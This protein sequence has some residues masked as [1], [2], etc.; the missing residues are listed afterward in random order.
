[1]LVYMLMIAVLVKM[2]PSMAPAGSGSVS[3]REK[4]ASLRGGV[5][6]IIIVFLIS[7]GGY[8]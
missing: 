5:V 7:I 2:Y 8:F 6:D 3:L 1:M 4:I